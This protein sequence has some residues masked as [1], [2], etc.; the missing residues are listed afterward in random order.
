MANQLVSASG[1]S[2]K[3]MIFSDPQVGNIPGSTIGFKRIIIQTKY[4]D[5]TIGDL[6]L[7]T[8]EV[9]SFGVGETSDMAT[10]VLN[11]YMM[12]LAL[13]NKNGA[14]E[15]EKDWVDTFNAIAENAKKYVLEHKDDIEKY[16]LEPANLKKFNPLYW[17]REKGKVVE[18]TGPTLYAKLI[19]SKKEGIKINSIFYD[20][21]GNSI[22][23]LSLIGKYA[24]VKAAIKIE[25]IFIGKDISLQVKLYEA[26]VKL[27]QTGMQSLMRTNRPTPQKLVS[28]VSTES[29]PLQ[30]IQNDDDDDDTVADEEP[31]PKP[32]APVVK[33]VIKKVIKK[34][35][36]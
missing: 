13:W 16:D 24:H 22:D 23:P 32:V 19:T 10:K 34:V 12:S 2:V 8:S 11:G 3:N 15:E 35:E 26:E 33:K 1:Y 17:K 27:L 7:P 21:E 29:R 31:A 25:S 6:I 20:A 5:G 18:G 36:G 9:F 14:T 4:E 28:T 30:N